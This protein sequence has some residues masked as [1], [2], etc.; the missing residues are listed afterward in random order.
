MS[1]DNAPNCPV[2]GNTLSVRLARGR[3]SNK[4]FI[5]IDNAFGFQ[6]PCGALTNKLLRFK[7]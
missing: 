5:L 3:K 1:T 4:A 2:C 6:S 7:M